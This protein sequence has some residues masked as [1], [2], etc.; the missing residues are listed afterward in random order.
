MTSCAWAYGLPIA[1]PALALLYAVLTLF[2]LWF[3]H[4]CDLD[5]M[6]KPVGLRVGLLA[7]AVAISIGLCQGDASLESV[8]LIGFV[9]TLVSLWFIYQTRVYEIEGGPPLLLEADSMKGK[10]VFV[11]GANAGIGKE[12]V[13]QLAAMGATVIMGCRSESRARAAMDDIRSSLVPRQSVDLK[14]VPLDLS[15]LASVRR[16]AQLFQEMNLPLD[17]LIN[18]AG[19]MMGYQQITKDGYELMMQANHLGHFL[20]TVLLLPELEKAKDARVLTLTSS[21]Y[22]L[23]KDGF[24]F[25][26]MFCAQTRKYTLFGQYSQS[27]LANILFTI[28][29]AKRY[30]NVQ[31]WAVHPG[32]V[33]TD[34]VRNMPWYLYYPNS[35]FALLVAAFQKRPKQGAYTTVWCAATKDPPKNASYLVSCRVQSTNEHATSAEVS[36]FV[37]LGSCHES[38]LLTDS[39]SL[40]RMQRGCGK[41]AKNLFT[42][43]NNERHYALNATIFNVL[44]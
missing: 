17:V 6:T 27:K 5:S 37:L 1:G 43:S 4:E 7:A 42:L 26:D 38:F 8:V 11:T 25:D 9:M 16:A 32:L 12:T 35:M 22:A 24:D 36:Y 44:A 14:F 41:S 20:L 21:T 33:R 3:W 2:F 28:E 10:V 39:C 15:D 29:L 13:R 19:V 18:N 23:A 40:L 34:V 30:P 31:S